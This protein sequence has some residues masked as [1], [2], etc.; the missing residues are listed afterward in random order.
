MLKIVPT[1]PSNQL[2]QVIEVKTSQNLIG[3]VI[4]L[5]RDKRPSPKSIGIKISSFLQYLDT[6]G[7]LENEIEALKFE[8]LKIMCQEEN[9]VLRK[10]AVTN[11]DLNDST[12]PQLVKR[13]RDK[14]SDIRCTVFRKL[15]K[16]KIQLTS[17]E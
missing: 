8:M 10:N 5:L 17:L 7:E 2:L 9:P 1:S 6:Q 14:D 15:I 4:G 11:L 3:A 16:E 12:F 13:I